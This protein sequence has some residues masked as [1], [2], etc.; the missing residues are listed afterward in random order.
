M[1]EQNNIAYY[2]RREERQRG[3][4]ARAAA[5]HIAAIHH[6]LADRYADYIKAHARPAFP[7]LVSR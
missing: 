4:A 6:Q 1:S 2:A 7:Q 3:L 5:P